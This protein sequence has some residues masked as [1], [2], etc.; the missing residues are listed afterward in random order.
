MKVYITVG[1]P[2]SGKSTWSK[3]F[4]KENPSTVI[5]NRDAFRT[6]IKDE[7]T[8]DFRYEPFIKDATNRSIEEALEHG[9]DVIV[10]ETH[11]KADR[12]MEIISIIRNFENNYGL[13]NDD[14]GKTKIICMW[15]TE[16]QNNL[17]FRMQN[18]RGYEMQKWEN[19][20]NSMKKI[21]EPP[22]IEEGYDELIKQNLLSGAK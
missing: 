9:L 11:I 1:L 21:F 19:V 5:V 13:I 18:S 6:M 16:D 12:R 8:F 15:F 17:W 2:G 7:Y 10:D 4:A 22:K 3:K 20:I 14:Y